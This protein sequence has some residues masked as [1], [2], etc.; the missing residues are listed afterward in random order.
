ML[1]RL[2]PF[3][4]L[5]NA[6]N[7]RLVAAGEFTTLAVTLLATFLIAYRICSTSKRNALSRR[8]PRF[9]KTLE[10]ILQSAAIHSL[11]LVTSA[12]LSAIPQTQSNN[13]PIFNA[14]NYAGIVLHSTT[15]CQSKYYF[16]LLTHNV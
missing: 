14:G 4:R 15:V 7:N 9:H 2:G 10:I 5:T 8:K 12:L 13:W 6:T 11:A 3:A 16:R 1:F